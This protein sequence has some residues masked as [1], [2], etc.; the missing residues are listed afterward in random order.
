MQK[1]DD[2][3]GF[4]NFGEAEKVN[5][6]KEL[7]KILREG[8]P[9]GIHTLVWCDS[10]NNMNRWFDRQTLR[11]LGLALQLARRDGPTDIAQRLERLRQAKEHDLSALQPHLG[12]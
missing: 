5:T 4:S 6:A 2:D 10:Y 9:Q 11:D 7:A 3:F 8:P 1:S 12:D